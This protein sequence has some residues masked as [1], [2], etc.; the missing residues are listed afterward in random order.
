MNA[1][2]PV[3]HKLL[4]LEGNKNWPLNTQDK[5]A[6]YCTSKSDT[7]LR[8]IGKKSCEIVSFDSAIFLQWCTWNFLIK[9]HFRSALYWFVLSCV[10]FSLVTYT[11]L[12]TSL[13]LKIAF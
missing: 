7:V 9:K 13:P 5:S 8:V 11:N 4:I 6:K 3:T 10:Q 2:M 1:H 12:V